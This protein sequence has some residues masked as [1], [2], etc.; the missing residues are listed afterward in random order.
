MYKAV[1]F[2]LDGTIADSLESIAASANN[3]LKRYGF[4]KHP[5]ENYKQ[6]AGDGTIELI[7]RCLKDAGDLDLKYFHKVHK[8]YIKLFKTGCMYNVKPYN[9]IK[10]LLFELKQNKIKIAVLSNKPHE[11]AVNVAEDLF[12][13]NYFDIIIGQSNRISRKPSPEGAIY[14]ADFFNLK[15][16]E[17]IYVGD[18]NTDMITG[19][20]AGMFTVGVTWGFRTRKELE[21]NKADLIIDKPSEILSIGLKK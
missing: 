7:K 9:G 2:D 14:I 18:T 17:C 13:R 4:E 20:S 11:N 3:A 5:I 6:Y 10:E 8:E 21:N 12:G 15:T 16:N 1:I 19:K